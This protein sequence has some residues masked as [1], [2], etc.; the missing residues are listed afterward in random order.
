MATKPGRGGDVRPQ[1]PPAQASK[2]DKKRQVLSEKLALLTD[3]MSQRSCKKIQVDLNLVGRVDPYADRPLDEIQREYRELSQASANGTDRPNRTLL[4]M[5]GPSFQ[6]WVHNVEDLIETRDYDL[7]SQKYEYER[8]LQ[9]N[10]NTCAYKIEVAKREYRA[11]SATLQDR[12]I[13]AI[14]SKKARLSREEGSLGDF[15][16]LS[17]VPAPEP[18]QLTNPSSPGGTHAKRT[19]RLRREMEEQA[20]YADNKKRKRNGGDEDGSPA[21]SEEPSTAPTLPLYG[22]T[23]ASERCA[24]RRALFYSIDKLFTD[25]ELSMNYNTAAL[26]SYKYLLTRRDVNGNVITPPDDSEAGNG[27]AHDEDEELAAPTMERQP[28]HATRSTRGGQN[29]VHNFLDDKVLGIEGLA[30]FEIAG[31]LDKMGTQE[32]KLPH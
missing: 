10:H 16:Q 29:N 6:D 1:S 31:N 14:T 15:R 11:L 19:T 18:I 9:E 28:S 4:E 12:L 21:P 2:R 3:Q 8:R 25:K 24:R 32:P 27:D 22:R 17:V 23:T 20:G 5:A 7:T 13:N 30:N 26:A